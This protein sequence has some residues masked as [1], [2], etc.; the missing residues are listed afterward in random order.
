MLSQ[1]H[2]LL[3]AQLSAL[4]YAV[5]AADCVPDDARFPYLT[6]QAEPSADPDGMGCVTLTA[7]CRSTAAH[8]ERMAFGDL[9]M[10]VVPSAGLPLWL[11][12]GLAVC[13]R[14]QQ[15]A[16]SY[17][18]AKGALGVR[19]QHDLRLYLNKPFQGGDSDA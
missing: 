1:L 7:W 18:A 17:P 13:W 5:Y 16:I 19:V 4:G 3:Y 2:Q 14:Q 12:G 8:S 6:F 11:D 9:L 10:Q 15:A